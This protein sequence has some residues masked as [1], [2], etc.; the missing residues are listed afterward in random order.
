MNESIFF[1]NID[2]YID[3][4]RK[5]NFNYSYKGFLKETKTRLHEIDDV[6][7]TYSEN[8]PSTGFF[9]HTNY[10]YYNFRFLLS[11][12]ES[13]NI[14]GFNI[15]LT[16]GDCL[17]GKPNQAVEYERNTESCAINVLIPKEWLILTN[18]NQ[19]VYR[20]NKINCHSG[21]GKIIFKFTVLLEEELFDLDKFSRSSLI[22]QYLEMIIDWLNQEQSDFS[23]L[24]LDVL[25]SIDS[26]IS[27]PSY[28]LDILSQQVKKSPRTV[29]KTLKEYD[30]T[31]STYLQDKR[32]LLSTHDL[33]FSSLNI[34]EI[35]IKWGFYDH[36]HFSKC[37]KKKYS[38]TPTHYKNKYF[39]NAECPV[40][41]V[42]KK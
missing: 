23:A 27:N 24:L 21:I 19:A 3:T 20:K 11:G 36:S 7:M 37:F 28:S 14:D 9:Y 1:E 33:L 42:L 15:I 30:L 13:Y 26:N 32:L 8:S 10:S 18:D 2:D 17:F 34:T 16:P 4:L 31:F 39:S 35:A 29:Q 40:E 5:L 25:N 6:I 38:C 12:T 22:K 41:C